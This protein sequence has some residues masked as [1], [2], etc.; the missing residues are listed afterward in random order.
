MNRMNRKKIDRLIG[1]LYSIAAISV[2]LGAFFKL[3]HFPYGSQILWGGFIFGTFVSIYD[4]IRL[5]KII[6]NLE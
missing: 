4:N 6:K 5:K 3:Q 1:I 2:L